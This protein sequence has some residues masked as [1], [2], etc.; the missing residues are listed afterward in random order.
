MNVYAERRDE[1]ARRIGAA[2]AIV[3]AARHAL[4]NSD[5]EYDYRQNSDFHYLTGFGE[6]EEHRRN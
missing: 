6:P 5:A 1:V 4:R 3:P 2:V